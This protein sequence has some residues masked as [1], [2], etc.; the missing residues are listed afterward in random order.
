MFFLA[1]VCETCGRRF[2]VASNL[3]RHVRRCVLRPV[4][5]QTSAVEGDDPRTGS[6]NTA[7]QESHSGTATASSDPANANQT[8]SK[9]T[10]SAATSSHPGSFN[11]SDSQA[12]SQPRGG[13]PPV[14]PKQRPATKRR[15]RAPSPTPWIPFSLLAFDLNPVEFHKST[16]V[17]LPPV[18]PSTMGRW[19]EE[20][21]SWDENVG[22]APYH[23]DWTGKL[24]G[25][26]LGMGLGL[27]LGLGGRDVG[28]LAGTGGYFMGRLSLF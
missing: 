4:N 5:S 16:P 21:N 17:P 25:P 23:R 18:S 12:Q 7:K 20:R 10:R 6:P 22:L 13:P 26:G 15:R 9:R 8:K 27:G 14:D 1:F 28:N 19:V 3:N 11:Q 2:G 24:P